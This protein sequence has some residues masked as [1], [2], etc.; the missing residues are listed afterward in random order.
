MPT[1]VG[2]LLGKGGGR[3][4]KGMFFGAI[5]AAV[6]LTL[7]GG[8]TTEKSLR[9]RGLSPLTQS[10]LEALYARTRVIRGS[11]PDGLGL[12]GTYTKEGG[13]RLD[14]G[15]GAAEGSWRII[16]GK[17]CTKYKV[18]RDGE[19]R[20]FT[21]YKTEENEYKAFLPDGTFNGMTSF[22]N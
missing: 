11:S 18:I 10:E 21:I 2:R 22:I 19:E 3:I 4:M 17:F 14:W 9:E 1:S 13:A 20:C 5:L 6:F 7:V 16:E 8:A 12:T 15:R